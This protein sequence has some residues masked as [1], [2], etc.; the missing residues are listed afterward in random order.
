MKITGYLP[1]EETAADLFEAADAIESGYVP[2]EQFLALVA[3]MLRIEARATTV[4][5]SAFRGF[6]PAPVS[7]HLVQHLKEKSHAHTE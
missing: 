3:D 1:A 2:D 5:G 7:I 4:M 6:S